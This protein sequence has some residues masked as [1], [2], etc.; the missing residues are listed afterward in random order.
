VPGGGRR[1]EPLPNAS[2]GSRSQGA[3]TEASHERRSGARSPVAETPRYPPRGCTSPAGTALTAMQT[4]VQLPPAQKR[5]MAKRTRTRFG[6]GSR[7][8][9]DPLRAYLPRA[10][11]VPRGGTHWPISQRSHP[12]RIRRRRVRRTISTRMLCRTSCRMRVRMMM[13]TRTRTRTRPH[14][15]TVRM[16]TSIQTTRMRMRATPTKM[17]LRWWTL[18][19]GLA[20][21]GQ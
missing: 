11:R 20:Q 15:I 6:W 1:S 7:S 18:P 8:Q 13:M 12:R 9:A 4:V 17:R 3:A 21:R 16:A 19:R 5:R 10:A 14:P 2:L